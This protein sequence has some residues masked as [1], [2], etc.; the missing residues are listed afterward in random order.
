MQRMDFYQLLSN[1]SDDRLTFA[2]RLAEKAFRQS[3]SVLVYATDANQAEQLDRMLWALREDAFIPHDLW[4]QDLPLPEPPFILIS[5]QDNP[6]ALPTLP[7]SLWINLSSEL[8]APTS[9]FLRGAEIIIEDEAIKAEMRQH[10]RFFKQ[11]GL[12]CS[13]HKISSS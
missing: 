11:Q 13:L 6:N 7:N 4:Q 10:Y 9:G 3:L 1:N 8:K 12:A 2:C 5:W